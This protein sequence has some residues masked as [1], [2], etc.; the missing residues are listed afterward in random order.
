M[1]QNRLHVIAAIIISFLLLSP[2]HLV[3]QGF[4]N[5][6]VDLAPDMIIHN[7]TILT[8][9]QS[10]AQ[11][12]AVAI[13]GEYILAVGDETDILAMAGSN[14]RII[15]LGGRTLLPG[16][17]DSHSH[18]IGDLNL[19]NQSTPEEA[20][21]TVLSSGWTSISELFVNQERLDELIALDQLDNLHVR[22]N[23]YLPLN[24][25]FDRFGNWYQSYQPRQEFSSKLRIGGVKIFMDGW[26]TNWNHYFNQ[27]E[28]NILVQEA[29]DAGFQI[30]IHSATDN[31]TDIVLN[32]L[33][34]ALGG[35]SNQLH[36][37]RIEHLVLLRDD[38]L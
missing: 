1:N 33:E 29:H 32:S 10:P 24:Y 26:I 18:W 21:E 20:I 36:R 4:G 16:F 17:I 31:G 38:Q 15:D 25:Q 12:E 7:G 30:A 11:V 23:A 5:R 27:T 22:V 19:V 9:E 28:L 35:Q 14:T 13:Q 37:H 8:M 2:A 34:S 3:L 6:N